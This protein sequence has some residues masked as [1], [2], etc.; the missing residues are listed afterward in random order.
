MAQQ[1]DSLNAAER[2][3]LSLAPSAMPASWQVAAQNGTVGRPAARRN[4]RSLIVA[5]MI[6]FGATVGAVTMVVVVATLVFHHLAG[7]QAGIR[8]A[9]ALV[10]WA[11]ITILAAVVGASF[12][13]LP[14]S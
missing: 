9:P 8:P 2:L 11:A 6:S 14:A 12:I 1:Y 5:T 3:A 10:P 7:R 13:S 4:R